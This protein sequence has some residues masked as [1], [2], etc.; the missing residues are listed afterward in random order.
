MC[1]IEKKMKV[2]SF[3]VLDENFLLHRKRALRLLAL[4]KEYKKS[5]MLNIFSS[6]RVIKSYSIDEIVGLGI[7]WVWMGIEGR[8]SQYRKLKDIDTFQLVKTLQAHG[9]RVLGSSIVGLEEHTPENIEQAI[10]D[11]VAHNTDFHQFMLY[12]PN[13]GTPLYEKHKQDGT[14]YPESVFPL[15][16]SMA[17]TGL[18]FGTAISMT[19]VKKDI[20]WMPL[21]RIFMSM[22]R[23]CFG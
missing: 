23:A 15:A 14:L 4:M 16:D 17:S 10:D 18:I 20:C 6:A 13:P 8:S 5:W 22:G 9:V 2:R 21:K 3:F 1:D 11:A 12:T 7:G 19:G